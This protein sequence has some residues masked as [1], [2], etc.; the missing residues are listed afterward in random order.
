[1]EKYL[2][3]FNTFVSELV[4]YYLHMNKNISISMLAEEI[5]LSDSFVQKVLY[6]PSIKHFN[7]THIF[8]ISQALNLPVNKLLPNKENYKLLTNK[9]I[10]DEDWQVFINNIKKEKNEL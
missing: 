4:N 8:L 1:M 6:N 2:L 7:L 10:S 3:D 5:G 9:E